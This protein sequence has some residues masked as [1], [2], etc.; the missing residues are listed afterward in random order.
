MRMSRRMLFALLHFKSC[1]HKQLNISLLSTLPCIV[2]V[3][4]FPSHSISLISVLI[5]PVYMCMKVNW[6]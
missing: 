6:H 5:L 1:D 3:D 2:P 4:F